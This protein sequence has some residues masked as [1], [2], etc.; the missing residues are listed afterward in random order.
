MKSR[1]WFKCTNRRYSRLLSVAPLLCT[2][3]PEP[4]WLES[5]RF[6]NPSF[7]SSVSRMKT[8]SALALQPGPVGNTSRYRIAGLDSPICS[9]MWPETLREH[10][11]TR[12][13]IGLSETLM[14]PPVT[15]W[16][17]PP[18]ETGPFDTGSHRCA[19]SASSKGG[20]AEERRSNATRTAVSPEIQSSEQGGRLA[21]HLFTSRPSV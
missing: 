3:R 21:A 12:A 10:V 6:K 5:M 19:Q 18:T 16:F 17:P 15:P 13:T 4:Y 9:W 11:P 1:G 7:E 8:R 14:A 20:G 2:M